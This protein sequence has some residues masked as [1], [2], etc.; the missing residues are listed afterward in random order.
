MQ[1]PQLQQERSGLYVGIK[2]I[3]NLIK[4][5]H[6]LYDKMYLDAIE[7]NYSHEQM[8][9]LNCILANSKIIYRRLEKLFCEVTALKSNGYSE[10]F[11]QSDLS[12]NSRILK[13]NEG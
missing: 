4:H 11:N 1:S 5:Q 3:T 13:K 7:S 12:I 8:T 10:D 6:R 9:P 2:N